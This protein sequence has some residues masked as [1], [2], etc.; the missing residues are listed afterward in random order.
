V[1]LRAVTDE[2][3]RVIG[4]LTARVAELERQLGRH[5]QNSSKPPSSDG[6]AKPPV[7]RRQ[8]RGGRGPGKQPGG[9][10]THLAQVACPDAVVVYRPK[11]CGGCGEDL[12]LAVVVGSTARQVFDLPAVR[13]RVVEHR[14]ERR[15][16]GCGHLTAADFPAQARAPAC[17]GPGVRA[18]GVYLGAWQHLPVERAAEL[19]GHLLG[20]PVSGGWVAGLH[21]E[22]AAGLDGFTEQARVHLADAE[23]VHFDEAG[24]RVCGRLHWVHSASTPLWSYFTVHAKRGKQAMDAAGVLPGFGGVAVHDFWSPYWRYDQATHAVCA[25]HL[26]REL[27]EAAA[28]PGQGWAG[29]LAEWL[30]IAIE[31]AAGARASGAECLDA[32]TTNRLRCRYNQ[33]IAKGH[34]ANPPLSPR[35]GHKRRR[36]KRPPAVCLLERLDTHRDEVR[37]FL[38]DL[39]VPPT[40]NQVERDI[41]MVKLQQKISARREAPHNRVEV[42]GLRHRPVAAGW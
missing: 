11:R 40:N 15:R 8:R 21:A 28:E 13:L 35:P 20:A 41:R 27:E 18:L 7:S 6:L 9:S 14:A 30:T 26:L 29:E 34:A 10:G 3:A 17:Y 42:K 39:R 25:A 24:A 23:V 4:A 2:Q 36:V 5:S 16:C 33:I 38:T 12:T 22:A 1:E 32:A 37:R 31:V 19:L